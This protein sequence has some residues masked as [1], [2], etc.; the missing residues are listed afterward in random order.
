MDL[1]C[2][3]RKQN[4]SPLILT[5]GKTFL[6]E[7]LLLSHHIYL[8]HVLSLILFPNTI[9]LFR[10]FSLKAGICFV[11]DFKNYL[12]KTL[13]GNSMIYVFT[14]LMYEKKRISD[15]YLGENIFVRV[16]LLPLIN[17]SRYFKNYFSGNVPIYEIT[18]YTR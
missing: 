11:S 13:Y 5:G 8:I 2:F 6:L 1:L 7:W 18:N 14:F 3:N 4:L 17:K 16:I 12:K 15:S 9:S 10:I